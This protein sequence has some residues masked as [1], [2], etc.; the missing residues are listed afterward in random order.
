MISS[1]YLEATLVIRSVA[2]CDQLAF[3]IA[4]GDRAG[5]DRLICGLLE[6]SVATT[7]RAKLWSLR[8]DLAIVH[9]DLGLAEA[10]YARCVTSLKRCD[11]L[12][13]MTRRNTGILMAAQGRLEAAARCFIG[14]LRSPDPTFRREAL[15]ALAMLYKAAGLIEQATTFALSLLND[16]ANEGECDWVAVADAL[17]QEFTFAG[18]VL[19]SPRL[20]DHVYWSV[21]R[22]RTKCIALLPSSPL[23]LPNDNL[24]VKTLSQRTVHL[25][26]LRSLA[27]RECDCG[28]N[29]SGAGPEAA[30]SCSQRSRIGY[31]ETALAALAGHRHQVAAD[32]LAHLGM[33]AEVPQLKLV[34]GVVKTM[35]LEVLYC[36]SK[37]HFDCGR[38]REGQQGYRVYVEGALAAIREVT[39]KLENLY[40]S[41]QLNVVEGA[42]RVRAP[43]LPPK[44]QQAYDYLRVHCLR[45]DIS[46][47]EAASAAGLSERSLQLQFKRALGASPREVIQRM[48]LESQGAEHTAVGLPA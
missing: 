23:D 36:V 11:M 40:A 45:N 1:S 41:E 8:G 43:G 34:A 25:R 46:V 12:P 33:R 38:L 28:I 7:D 26:R 14:N 22:S 31:V 30:T 37:M 21:R 24:V 42:E 47:G 17:L 35:R 19:R 10:A 48:R 9:G 18:E 6:K 4:R 16:V 39:A 32:A 2:H 5:V 29:P 13:T 27:K 20:S 15:V 44:H 3:A